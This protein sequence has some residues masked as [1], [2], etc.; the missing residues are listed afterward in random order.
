MHAIL[1]R[2]RLLKSAAGAAVLSSIAHADVFAAPAQG[3][4]ILC[5]PNGA[6]L[7]LIRLLESGGLSAAAPGATSQVWRSTDELRAGIVSGRTQLFTTPT[8]VPANLFN[9]GLPVKLL[10]ILSRGH[11]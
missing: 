10:C 6:S 2:R 4:Q 7:V 1:S 3:L 5:A 9:R 8:H 11:L